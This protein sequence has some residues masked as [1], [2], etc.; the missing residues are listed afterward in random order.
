M[1][2]SFKESLSFTILI[3]RLFKFIIGPNR[4]LIIVYEA[5]L[6]EQSLAL[7]TLIRGEMAESVASESR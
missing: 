7:A 1:P 3:S 6:V 4:V 5:V 2:A